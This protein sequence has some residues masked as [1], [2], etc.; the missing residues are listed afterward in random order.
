MI[1]LAIQPATISLKLLEHMSRDDAPE[2]V[3]RPLSVADGSEWS[4]KAMLAKETKGGASSLHIEI[5]RKQLVS[6]SGLQ[7][8]GQP[9]DVKNPAHLE[10]IG[11]NAMIEIGATLLFRSALT[12]IEAGK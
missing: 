4:D 5:F 8:E 7:I 3:C 1:N 6:V 9:F 10:A 2:F 11:Y 12:E